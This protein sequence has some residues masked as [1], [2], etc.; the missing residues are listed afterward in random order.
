MAEA[1]PPVGNG[2]VRKTKQDRKGA[3]MKHY[4]DA[5]GLVLCVI[6]G[7]QNIKNWIAGADYLD[8]SV[9]AYEEWIASVNRL[10]SGGL[11]SRNRK[12]CLLYTS[13]AADEL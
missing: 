1:F 6:A 4:T 9:P 11:I 5:D 2:A 3:R 7:K 13:D 8:R 12:G 10:L